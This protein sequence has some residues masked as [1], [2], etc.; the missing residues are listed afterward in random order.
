MV[1]GLSKPGYLFGYT[2]RLCSV[3]CARRR[4][5][6]AFHGVRVEMEHDI[7]CPINVLSIAQGQGLVRD[8]RRRLSGVLCA[9]TGTRKPT[10]QIY[11]IVGGS[12][13]MH[14]F[15]TRG[16]RLYPGPRRALSE[17]YPLLSGAQHTPDY[18]HR[19]YLMPKC[20]VG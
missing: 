3:V 15:A 17:L 14:L 10:M 6:E 18:P 1:F 11:K 19:L 13:S 16:R 2:R 8:Y 20:G 5:L 4:K 7:L 12:N 9:R